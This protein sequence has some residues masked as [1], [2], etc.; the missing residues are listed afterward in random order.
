MHAIGAGT[1]MHAGL[2]IRGIKKD[3][4][5]ITDDI[6]LFS[7]CGI[8]TDAIEHFYESLPFKI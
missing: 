7:K 6:L 4:L 3:P 8:L 2:I 1:R 5:P